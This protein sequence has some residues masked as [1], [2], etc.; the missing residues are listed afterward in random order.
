MNLQ[1]CYEQLGGNYA[2]VKKRIPGDALVEKFLGKFL[3]DKSYESLCRQMENGDRQAAFLAVHTL[4]GVCA[5]MSFTRLLGSVSRLTEALRP[6]TSST[7]DAE[8]AQLIGDVHRDYAATA[9]VIR[10][11]LNK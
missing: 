1:E 6:A 11:Y 2:E 5:N 3:E 8:I 9:E 4:K 10:R 7:S